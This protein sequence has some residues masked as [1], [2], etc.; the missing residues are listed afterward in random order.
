MSP[1]RLRKGLAEHRGQSGNRHRSRVWKPLEA[2]GDILPF[3][4]WR[5]VPG[6][7]RSLALLAIYFFI[8]EKVDIAI[9][10]QALIEKETLRMPS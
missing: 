1:L 5:P 4:K 8:S 2:P 6:Y 3:Q 9:V 10:E 7:P